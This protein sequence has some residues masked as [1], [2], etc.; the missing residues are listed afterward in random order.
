MAE[1]EEGH[2]QR[3]LGCGSL[4]GIGMRELLHQLSSSLPDTD[5]LFRLRET[6]HPFLQHFARGIHIH[7]VGVAERFA[8]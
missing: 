3:F 7:F 2:G 4:G 8:L 1:V 6:F 5:A